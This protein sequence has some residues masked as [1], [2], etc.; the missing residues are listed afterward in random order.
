MYAQDMLPLNNEAVS[1]NFI[2]LTDDE[3]YLVTLLYPIR[4]DML[5]D[6]YDDFLFPENWEDIYLTYIQQGTESLNTLTPD[7]WT[8]SLDVFDTLVNSIIVKGG[9]ES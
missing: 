9:F 3:A 2:G 6:S 5:I 4:T 8:P 7:Q 1:Y